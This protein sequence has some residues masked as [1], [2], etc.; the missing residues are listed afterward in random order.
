M[1]CQW[2]I[3]F[4]RQ[5]I[6]VYIYLFVWHWWHVNVGTFGTRVCLFCSLWYTQIFPS[7]YLLSVSN[8]NSKTR[9]PV[10]CQENL[11]GIN[12]HT[13]FTVPYSL[14]AFRLSLSPSFLACLC[15]MP[16]PPPLATASLSDPVVVSALVIKL[17]Y[18]CCIAFHHQF[19]QCYNWDRFP[20]LSQCETQRLEMGLVLNGIKFSLSL[21]QKRVYHPDT[22]M[23]FGSAF[24]IVCCVWEREIT[25]VLHN[26]KCSICDVM[27]MC[28]SFLFFRAL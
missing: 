12:V 26:G 24:T 17:H 16:S 6:C 27:H 10:K 1:G 3:Q 23:R 20:W 19:L 15:L 13:L 21:A 11:H 25:A 7:S 22:M 9:L 2:L 4:W 14:P 28:E 5:E 18:L 8:S